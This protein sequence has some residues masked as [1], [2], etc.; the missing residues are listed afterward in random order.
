M[1]PMFSEVEYTLAPIQKE[2]VWDGVLQADS[3]WC[4][5]DEKDFIKKITEVYKNYDFYKEMSKS[6]K[7]WIRKEFESKK[8][9]KAFAD[10]VLQRT[11]EIPLESM[12]VSFD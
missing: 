5:A 2:A 8:Q 3:S 11:E 6:L 4:Y 1:K 10:A 12:L 7:T 9:H